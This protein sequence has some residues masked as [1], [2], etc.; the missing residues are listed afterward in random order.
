M[1]GEDT[2]CASSC[3]PLDAADDESLRSREVPA[4]EGD[5][6]LGE[7][8]G[9]DP[10]QKQRSKDFAQPSGNASQPIHSLAKAA[11]SHKAISIV[12][13]PSQ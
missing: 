1:L 12:A 5:L 7:Q 10:A 6:E 3:P 4:Q 13:C 8:K 11:F 2:G 9:K